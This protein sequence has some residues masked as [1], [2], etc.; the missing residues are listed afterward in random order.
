MCED[1]EMP[2]EAVKPRRFLGF[3]FHQ[4]YNIFWVTD[5]DFA[6]ITGH[7]MEFHEPGF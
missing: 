5:E 7:T 4:H 6:Y 3:D 1:C 2:L